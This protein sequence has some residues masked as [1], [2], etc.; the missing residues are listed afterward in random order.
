MLACA[1]L[2]THHIPSLSAPFRYSS[3]HELVYDNDMFASRGNAKPCL[4]VTTK[5]AGPGC[6]VGAI[7]R[8]GWKLILKTEANAGWYVCDN[9]VNS[10]S[11]PLSS[12]PSYV[13]A[14]ERARER[15]H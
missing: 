10:P 5:R 9:S 11:P 14:R 2:M 1:T 7:Q 6:M 3:R 12:T 4:N 13:N 8:D 15:E